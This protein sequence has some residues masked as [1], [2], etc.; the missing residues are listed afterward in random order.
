MRFRIYFAGVSLLGTV[1]MLNAII[2]DRT[3]DDDR[4]DY[5]KSN[6]VPTNN[7]ELLPVTEI[8]VLLTF[9]PHLY[10]D[11]DSPTPIT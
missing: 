11:S 7:S 4:Q 3:P 1:I 6:Y 5:P 8:D 9:D 2:R 10:P